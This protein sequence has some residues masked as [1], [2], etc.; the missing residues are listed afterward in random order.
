MRKFD[1]LACV[2]LETTGARPTHD[3]VTEIGV[4]LVD[5]GEVVEEWSTLVDPQMPIPINI[6]QL[7]GIDDDMVARAPLFADVADILLEKI[8]G[9]VLVA[10]NARFD[11]GFL[12]NEL[13]RTG[14][15]FRPTT[16][17]TVKLSRKLY[18]EHRRHNLDIL[19]QRHQLDCDARHRALGDAQVLPALISSMTAELGRD[20]VE[21]AMATQQKTVS[22]PPHVSED[23][24]DDIPQRP[25]VYLFYGDNDALLYVG[26]SVN[27]RSRVMSHFASDHRSS[28]EM[29]LTQQLRHID[30]IET[31]GEFG[32]LMLEAELIK[33][34]SPIMNRRLRRQQELY[35]IVW[36]FAASGV[37]EITTVNRVE[38]GK[39]SEIFGLFRSK[40]QATGRLRKLADEH[41]LCLQQV[42]LEKG[43]GPCFA[44]QLKKCKGACCGEEPEIKHRQRLL[45]ALLP[46]RLQAW[47]YP[48]AIGIR[49]YQEETGKT[50][51]HVIDHW[52]Y[53]GKAQSVEELD[54]FALPD[55]LHLDKDFYRLCLRQLK[56]EPQVI[57]IVGV[58]QLDDIEHA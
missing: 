36:D 55:A 53:L 13:K 17:C 48:G 49:E 21:A 58:N 11:V 14:V 18:P 35:S 26:K 9:R 44:Y 37:P 24:L 50:D 7:T 29:R 12:R 8:E 31:A 42:G 56:K 25:G 34:R 23:L 54:D 41:G 6:Q 33:T 30:W 27:L 20:A 28:R 16:V 43:R 3:R 39:L 10:H 4:V 22:L 2:D 51:I 1:K 32:A 15:S 40:R 52:C 46:L 47:P 19:M 45:D 57:D 5:D 38:P